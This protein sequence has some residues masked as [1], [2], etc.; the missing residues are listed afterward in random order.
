MF[1]KFIIYNYFFH[2]RRL[3]NLDNNRY[4][5]VHSLY[6]YLKPFHYVHNNH[7]FHNIFVFKLVKHKLV[8]SLFQILLP[9]DK[10]HF[11][12]ICLIVCFNTSST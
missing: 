4:S 5:F 11:L 9:V 7:Y 2:K 12:V 8:Y 6:I 3:L 1:R 10:Q